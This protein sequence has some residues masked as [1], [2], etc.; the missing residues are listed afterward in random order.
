MADPDKAIL[1]TQ[2]MVAAYDMGRSGTI[3]RI[4]RIMERKADRMISFS[5][6]F[7]AP[8]AYYFRQGLQDSG[9]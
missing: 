7:T 6:N 9:I 1:H 5:F 2:N 8:P 3:F 4:C